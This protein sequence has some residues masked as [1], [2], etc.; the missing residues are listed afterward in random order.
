[1]IMVMMSMNPVE[2]THGG[3]LIRRFQLTRW[4]IVGNAK[5]MYVEEKEK[6]RAVV[7][8]DPIRGDD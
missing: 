2:R 6:R 7:V 4:I 3:F 5:H 8:V 1:M